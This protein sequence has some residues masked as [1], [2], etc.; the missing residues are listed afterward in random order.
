MSKKNQDPPDLGGLDSEQVSRLADVPEHFEKLKQKSTKVTHRDVEKLAEREAEVIKKS[1][2]VPGTLQKFANQISLL[3]EMLKDYVKG[4]YKEVPY[5]SIA[6]IVVSLLYF[7]S[8][9]DLIPDVIPVVGYVDDAMVVA[10]TVKVIQNDLR[11]YCAWKGY[12]GLKYF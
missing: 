3:F 5:S 9:I 11:N 10:L 4:E 6:M 12:D 1:A 8:P 7:L 2:K